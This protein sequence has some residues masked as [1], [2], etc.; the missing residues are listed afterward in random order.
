MVVGTAQLNR[1]LSECGFVPVAGDVLSE[2]VHQINNSVSTTNEAAM[3]LAQ[4]MH[5]SGG[6]RYREEISRGAGQPYGS[7]YGRGYI[8]LTWRENYAAAS[9]YLFGDDRLVHSPDL[10]SANPHMSMLVSVWYWETR[11][12]PQAAPFRNFYCTTKAING[13][14]ENSPNHPSAKRRYS[15]Y[16]TAAR[17]LGVVNLASEA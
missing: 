3:F 4:L 13:G 9:S 7:Y 17:V 2:I 11:V 14:I 6:F 1:V 12:R 5:E 10:V 8:Q 15:F 16:C